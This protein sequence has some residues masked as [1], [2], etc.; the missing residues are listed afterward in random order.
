[1]SSAGLTYKHFGKEIVMN[2]LKEWNEL[3]NN[4]DK[5]DLIYNRLYKNFIM[6]VDAVDNGINMYP[7]DVKPK[8]SDNTGYGNRVSR[9]NPSWLE[10]NPD[11]SAQ[12]KLAMDI[13]ED[14]FLNQLNSIIRNWIPGY[15]I[16]KSSIEKR[17]EFHAS[18]NIVFLE[19]FCPWKEHLLMIEEEMNL[20]DE[21]KFC[22]YRD[23][24]GSYRVQT[25]PVSMGSFNYRVGIKEEWR[26]L[27]NDELVKCSNIGD[28]V[29]VHTSG[30][31]GGAKS[32]ESSIKM[33]EHSLINK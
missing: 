11:Q 27:R 18:G 29:F 19:R 4:K 8:Y 5:I 13:A 3:D 6:S 14:E 16:V 20:K 10:E 24:D 9:M 1:M 12:F 21:I 30:F 25:I 7:D 23:S 15:S 17:K 33:A 31:I 22:I 2:I 26:G 32:L 28:I